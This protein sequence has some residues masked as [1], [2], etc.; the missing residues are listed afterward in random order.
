MVEHIHAAMQAVDQAHAATE[1]LRAKTDR[2]AIEKFQAE[3]KEL[4]SRLEQM[5]K[6]LAHEDT[7]ALDELAEALGAALGNQEMY[8]RIPH[9]DLDDKK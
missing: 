4:H 8:H 6:I 7:Y 9:Y 1:S 2:E 5:Q 3:M